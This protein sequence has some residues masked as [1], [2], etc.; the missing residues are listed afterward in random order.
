MSEIRENRLTG[1]W[2]IIAPER[3]KRGTNLA[4]TGAVKAEV[5]E[6]LATCPF[7]PGNEDASEERYRVESLDGRWQ[8]R[9]VTNK[10]SA[11]S[12]TG[13]LVEHR[14]RPGE[15]SLNA[16]G[17]HEVLVESR[18]HDGAL[19]LGPAGHVLSVLE[20][21]R[22]RFMAF[23]E[24]ARVRHVIVFKNYGA[25]AGASQQHPHSQIV[26]L[27]IV[28]GQVMERIERSRRHYKAHGRCL[29]CTMLEEE[30]AGRSRVVAENGDFAA[31]IPYAALSPYHLWIFPKAHSGCF[32]LHARLEGLAE[33]LLTVLGKV[34]GMLGDP[35]YNLV[36]RSLGPGENDCEYFHWYLSIV[37]RVN[38]V[39]GFELG[40]G[41]YINPSSPEDRA[42]ALRE[43]RGE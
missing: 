14:G 38:K 1:E 43:W 36:F 12:A 20:A 3:A 19:A 11:L 13:E 17:P 26:G 8:M 29:G 33:I 27:P 2:V 30:L 10:Y 31:F 35:A 42:A 41:M 5:P 28:P 25:E 23:S 37:P 40:T 7:C 32:A 15:L 24:D 21:Y 9:S 6:V 16:V 39:A 18:R 4:G 22:E 34:R